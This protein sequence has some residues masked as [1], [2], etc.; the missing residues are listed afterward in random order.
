MGFQ[1]VVNRELAPA[2]AGDFA[3]NN[4]RS[5]LV[6]PV[7]SGFVTAASQAVT[8]GYFAW[9]ATT[10]L[11]YSSLAGAGS[12][13]VLGFVARQPNIPSVLITDFL[14]ESRMT[15]NAGLPA[16]LQSAGDYWASLAGAAPGDTVY[17]LRTT[18]A[19][20]LDDD[21]AQ[22]PDTGFVVVSSARANAVTNSATT[23]AV[24]TGIMTVAAMAGGSPDIEV[25]DR[26]T[27]TGVPAETYI[28]RQISGTPGGA[29]T[30]QTTS[31]NR[32]A[33]SAFTATMVQG[34]LVKIS[35]VAA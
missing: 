14:G 11:V 25:G 7:D 3:S 35:R 26:V 18:G 23:I 19:P 31:Y 9:G 21:S 28:T 1:R 6:P 22:N 20:T 30:Y 5:S 32:A 17:A 4:P 27:G 29:G 10:G 33:V 15:L 16:T 13:P 34:S 2:V 24:N 8:V 12:D